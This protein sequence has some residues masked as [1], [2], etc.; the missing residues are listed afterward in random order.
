MP[1]QADTVSLRQRACEAG[2]NPFLNLTK[3]W[4]AASCLRTPRN[5]EKVIDCFAT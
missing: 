1:L 3:Q 5:D 4:I 2:S